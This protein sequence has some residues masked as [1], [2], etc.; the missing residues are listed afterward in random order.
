MLVRRVRLK[1]RARSLI[2]RL[3]QGAVI[4]VVHPPGCERADLHSEHGCHFVTRSGL[5]FASAA[6][7]DLAVISV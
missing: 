7:H 1:G 5:N 3:R 4:E 2:K 6:V